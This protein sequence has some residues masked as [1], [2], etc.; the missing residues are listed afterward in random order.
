MV[1]DTTQMIP[2]TKREEWILEICNNKLAWYEL[3]NTEL[4]KRVENVERELKRIKGIIS[5]GHWRG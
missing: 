4:T 5:R 3:K 2:L 1:I